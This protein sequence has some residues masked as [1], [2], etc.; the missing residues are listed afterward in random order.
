MAI[1]KV[2]FFKTPQ[3]ADDYYY[4]TE[5]TLLQDTKVYDTATG[6]LTLDVMA[7]DL[8]GNAKTLYSID[9]GNGNPINPID[10]FNADTLTGGVSAWELTADGNRARINN[11]KVEFDLS[12]E[13]P[14]GVNSLGAGDQFT[15]TFIYAIRL[16]NGTLSWAHVHI[17]ID[18]ANDAAT[19]T[20]SAG[21]DTTVVEAGGVANGT[22]GDPSASGKLTV[23]DLDAGENK[24][25]TPASLD[26]IYG[27]FTF[28]EISGAWTYT[29]DQSKAD[30]LT[31]GEAATDKLTVTSYDGT[32]S[33]D[34]KIDITGSNDAPVAKDDTDSATEDAPV[35]NGSVATNDSDADAGAKLTYTL[36]APVA[37]LTLNDDG[38]YSFDPADDA[39]QHLAAGKTVDVVANY[40]VTDDKG[41]TDTGKLTIT[42]T[43]VNDAP[44][45]TSNDGGDEA[46]LSVAENTSAVTKVTATDPDDGATLEYK[47]S[48]GADSALFAIDKDGTLSFIAAPNFE[49]PGDEDKDNVYDVVVQAWDGLAGDTQTL[50]VTVTDVNEQ[51]SAGADFAM[52]AK[53]DVADTAVLATVV[54]SDPDL[55]G[56]NDGAN[57][58][59]D[60]SYAIAPG[61]DPSGLFEID[62]STGE[63]SLKTGSKLDFEAAQSHVVTVRV[64]DGGGLFD[65]TDVTINVTDVNETPSAGAD[66]AV[67]A[68]ED[69]ADTAVLATVVG[70]DP[71][72]G[73]GNDGANNFENLSYSIA[74]G[75][76]ASGLFEINP[77]TGEI[78]LKTGSKLDFETAQSHVVT[79]RVTDGGG[80]F[81]DTDVTINVTD[82]NEAPTLTVDATPV[83]FAENTAAGT[84]LAD[85]DGTDPDLGGG[86]DGAN[87]FEN[88]TYSITSG[89]AAGLF[90]IDSANGEISLAAGKSFDFEATQQYILTIRVTDGP[91]LFEEKTVTINVTD[92]NEAP[93][94]TVDATPVTVAENAAVGTVVGDVDGTDPDVGGG[95]DGANNFEDLKYSIVSVDGLTSGA[96]Y[97][98]FA[99]DSS[100]GTVSLA[101]ALDYETDQSYSIVIKVEDG[102]GLFAQQTLVVNVTDVAEGDPNDFDDKVGTNTPTQGSDI[103]VG[104]AGNDTIGALNGDDTVYGKAGNDT[105]SGNNDNDL[106]YGGSGND[107]INGNNGLDQLFG[108]SG[109][110]TIVGGGENDLIVG[111]QDTDTLQGQGGTDTFTYLSLKDGKDTISDF[112]IDAPNTSGDG[113]ILDISAVLDIAGNTWTDGKDLT[114]AVTNGYISFTNSG[115]A[116]QVN[117]D[118][119]GAGAAFAPTALAVLTGV[120]PASAATDLSDNVVLG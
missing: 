25:Q 99:I 114:F 17:T 69:V 98:L 59:E 11:G 96:I 113:D 68:K 37:G 24:F 120:N 70:S 63:I 82:V 112:D 78:S 15:D 118:I 16:G 35:V 12:N 46:S 85:V 80:L 6:Y 110:D 119:D 89:N 117:V 45:I 20:A 93:I 7:N 58:F 47:I 64:T 30:K 27:T 14:G 1:S 107:N 29:L 97:S 18:G 53:E 115:G 61:G 28:D 105:L 94:L 103:L 2:S 102:P 111:G 116:T 38:T 75:G 26:G 8:G 52:S 48:G 86:N 55:G 51:P 5:D 108:G 13:L 65:D 54:G 74:P 88:L 62:P 79:V 21:A 49:A 83:S 95:N 42:I 10:L 33:Y 56:G 3:A 81:D 34:I 77:S 101:G 4:W 109:N 19:I 106:I 32:A 71:D 92:V 60:L 72:L 76:D 84:V 73:G 40:T 41:A 50:H 87:N 67:S 23:N 9:D 43:G 66:F 100:T 22:A 36:D 90:A 104:T 44:T 39:Y 91:G 57:N 31:G